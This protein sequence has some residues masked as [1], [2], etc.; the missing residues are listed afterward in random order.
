MSQI[1]LAAARVNAGLT[2]LYVAKILDV[3]PSTVRN[4]EKGLTFPK[5][6]YIEK[7][8]ELYGVAYDNIKFVSK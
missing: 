5:Q 7:M 8:C 4:W 3:D 6:P 2:Q 1:T